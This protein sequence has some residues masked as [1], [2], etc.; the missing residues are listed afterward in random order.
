MK[1]MGAILLL[2]QLVFAADGEKDSVLIENHDMLEIS[3]NFLNTYNVHGMYDNSMR[4]LNRLNNVNFAMK[5]MV[6]PIKPFD[7]LKIHYAYPLKIFLPAG[8]TVT[9]AILSNS[10]SEPSVS[11]NVVTIKCE[12]EFVSG[13]LDIVYITD[14]NTKEAKYFSVKLDKYIPLEQPEVEDDRLYTQ[15]QYFQP[16]KMSNNEILSA[17]KPQEYEHEYT[18]IKYMGV[19]YNIHLVNIVEDKKIVNQYKEPQYINSGL[20]YNN[21]TYNFYIE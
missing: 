13:L 4:T 20:V 14:F 1:L 10:S 17:L 12:E 15:V 11:Q 5:P 7:E 16:K 21:R 18:Q 9:S 3:K 19:T 6:S 8:S 2:C